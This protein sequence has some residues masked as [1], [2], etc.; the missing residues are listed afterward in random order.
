M[1]GLIYLSAMLWTVVVCASDRITV[2]IVVTNAPDAGETLTINGDTRTW[3]DSVTSPAGEILTA[4]SIGGAT[5]NLWRAMTGAGFAGPMVPMWTATNEIRLTGAVGQTIAASFTGNW[6]VLTLST[7]TVSQAFVVRVPITAEPTASTRT[8]IISLLITALFNSGLST[9]QVAGNSTAMAN[10][11]NLAG[12]QTISGYKKCDGFLELLAGGI[13]DVRSNAVITFD[14]GAYMLFMTNVNIVD[15]LGVPKWIFSSVETAKAITTFGDLTNKLAA[16]LAAANA[17]T[18]TNSFAQITNTPI[19]GATITASSFSGTIGTATGGTLAA[20]TLTNGVHRGAF[21]S[22]SDDPSNMELGTGAAVTNTFTGGVALGQN[23]RIGANK[24]TAIGNGANASFANAAAIGNSAAATE[25]NQIRLGTTGEYV[26]A[27]GG[28]RAGGNTFIGDSIGT[29]VAG[30]T[31]GRQMTNGAAASADPANGIADF[32]VGGEWQYRSSAAGEGAG[33]VNR[34][35][36]RGAQVI[37]SG[38]DFTI[39]GTGYARVDF[40]GTDP[41]VALP[42]AGTY[43]V[44]ALVSIIAGASGNDDFRAKLRNSTDAEDIASSDRRTT[45]IGAGQTEQLC[46]QNVVTVTGAKTIQVYAQN[47]TAAR[48]AIEAQRTSVSYVRLY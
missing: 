36:N 8:N 28:F 7:Q 2:Q 29:F 40:G 42:T 3:A 12:T 23:A 13:L 46:L 47:L 18:G 15:S 14:P 48:G 11:V 30:M 41:E 33:Q 20:T 43:L 45:N 25:A 9:N 22:Y 6:G 5:T 44:T 1:K 38:A 32:S 21:R 10:F 17:W 19:V 34:V 27:P 39:T 4:P 26:S 35:H 31:H 16:L 24:G 37:G